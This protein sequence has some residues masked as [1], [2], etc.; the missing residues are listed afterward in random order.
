MARPKSATLTEAEQRLM[1][2][3]WE[4]GE[5]PVKDVVDALP[6][7]TA[8]A[9]NSVLTILRILERKGYVARRKEGRGHVYRPAVGREEAT[10]GAL[11]QLLSRFFG[12]SPEQ[13]VANILENEELDSDELSR[14]R[15]LVDAHKVRR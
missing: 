15:E 8:P 11:R 6:P 14:I 7:K 5:L 1:E 4:R 13:L 12:G 2:V 9:Y 10:S 3:L